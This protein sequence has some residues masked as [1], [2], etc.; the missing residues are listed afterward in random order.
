MSGSSDYR[1]GDA[2]TWRDRRPM[3]TGDNP[4][5][6]TGSSSS[7]VSGSRYSASIGYSTKVDEPDMTHRLD[8]DVEG[9]SSA[10]DAANEFL[11]SASEALKK[12][13]KAS[14][15]YEFL[16]DLNCSDVPFDTVD[17]RIHIP[18]IGPDDIGAPIAFLGAIKKECPELVYDG[19]LEMARSYM[20]MRN[21]YHITSGAGDDSITVEQ[22]V[23]GLS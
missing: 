5:H 16:N 20:G 10:F 13:G 8:V 18:E 3:E 12:G 17:T 9:P 4:I 11:S 6:I 22:K 23:E 1:K 21:T 19:I 2:G 15:K 7:S 14:G